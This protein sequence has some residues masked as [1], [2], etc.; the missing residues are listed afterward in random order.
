M[1]RHLLTRLLALFLHALHPLSATAQDVLLFGQYTGDGGEIGRFGKSY[2]YQ[3][4]GDP[5]SGWQT[6]AYDHSHWPVGDTP[7]SNQEPGNNWN[8]W[9]WTTYETYWPEHSTAYLYAEFFL[10]D[11]ATLTTYV[12]ID[13]DYDLYVNGAL[14]RSQTS[15]GFPYHWEYTV[16]VPQGSTRSGLNELALRIRDRGSGAGFD[17]AL[18][19]PAPSG[20]FLQIDAPD[21]DITRRQDETFTIAWLD[22]GMYGTEI[23]LYFDPDTGPEPWDEGGVRNEIAIPVSIDA[24]NPND[25]ITWHVADLEPGTYSVWGDS[26]NGV[27]PPTYSRAPGLV[28]V[29]EFARDDEPTIDQS[30]LDLGDFPSPVFVLQAPTPKNLL[31]VTHGWNGLAGQQAKHYWIEHVA[32]GIAD[33]IT[34]SGD[35][36]EWDVAYLDWTERA[37]GLIPGPDFAAVEALV[38]GSLLRHRIEDLDPTYTHIEVIAHSAGAWVAHGLCSPVQSDIPRYLTLLDAY[39]TQS[40]AWRQSLGTHA[41]HVFNAYDTGEGDFSIDTH[42]NLETAFNVDMT[43]RRTGQDPDR[44]LDNEPDPYNGSPHGAPWAW[45][46]RSVWDATGT[47]MDDTSYSAP[48]GFKMSKAYIGADGGF[49]VPMSRYPAN[50]DDEFNVCDGLWQGCDTDTTVFVEYADVFDF[51][52]LVRTIGPDGTVTVVPDSV[53]LTT[54]AEFAWVGFD[55]PMA[56]AVSAVLFDVEFTSADP[57]AEGYATGYWNGLQLTSADERFTDGADPGSRSFTFL[58]TVAPDE[59]VISL[60][61]DNNG[62][63]TSSVLISNLRTGINLDV[64]INGDC[65]ATVD[66]LCAWAAEPY[67]LDGN[68]IVD[69]DDRTILAA[70]LGVS[71]ADTDGDGIPDVCEV[72]VPDLN[73]DGLVNTQDFLVFLNA[74]SSGDMLADWDQNGEINTLD[75]LAYLNDWSAGC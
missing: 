41:V 67:D 17:L 49:D 68:G 30:R 43:C 70:A 40:D 71:D 24:S 55:V 29:T 26:N 32:L 42:E 21:T 20:P 46:R 2:R 50:G 19:G 11:P 8:N 57:D 48:L 10:D 73:D 63:P 53:E 72:C 74:W 58:D 5:G 60:R 12:A 75:F 61:L 22:D 18:F 39:V 37:G 45:Y 7:Y 65:V 33:Y 52:S 56:R 25:D 27:D 14:I 66:D 3:I 59:K 15:D 44:N 13:N 34:T 28:T 6:R 1:H 62:G 69:A 47:F 9:H 4:G 38:L 64:D 54:G 35:L 51:T 23:R 31:L 36:G 16:S